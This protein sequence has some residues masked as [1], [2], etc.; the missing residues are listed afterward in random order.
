MHG[1]PRQYSRP[2]EATKDTAYRCYLR[3]PDGVGGLTP[4]GTWSNGKTKPLHHPLRVGNSPDCRDRVKR[5]YARG[6]AATTGQSDVS[7]S[8]RHASSSASSS[9]SAAVR[10]SSSDTSMCS[11]TR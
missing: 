2:D 3:G 10:A 9:A 11:T 1:I 5:Q 4:F 8:S 7:P 6:G